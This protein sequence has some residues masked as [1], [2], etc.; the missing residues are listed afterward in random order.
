MAKKKMALNFNDRWQACMTPSVLE[1]FP[2]H[3]PRPLQNY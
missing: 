2:N 1:V 3:N